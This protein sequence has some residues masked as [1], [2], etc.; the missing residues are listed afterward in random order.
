MRVSVLSCILALAALGG[1]LPAL[2]LEKTAAPAEGNGADPWA[3]SGTCTVA[4]YN[5]ATGWTSS[6]VLDPFDRVG[7]VFVPCSP[8]PATLLSTT[9]Q[10]DTIPT[11]GCTGVVEIYAVDDYNCPLGPALAS[12]PQSVDEGEVTYTWDVEVPQRFLV[13][14]TVSYAGT[15]ERARYTVDHPAAEPTRSGD[16]PHSFD[17]GPNSSEFCEAAPVHDGTGYVELAWSARFAKEVA[18]AGSTWGSIKAI[19]R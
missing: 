6:W 10:V 16:E 5:F 19:Y 14:I 2:A 9:H 1:A 7:V 4:Y 18:I 15:A 8:H 17:Y 13:A 11:V 12:Q 3:S